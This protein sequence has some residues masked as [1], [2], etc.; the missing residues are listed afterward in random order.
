MPNEDGKERQKGNKKTMARKGQIVRG[1]DG[2]LYLVSPTGLQTLPDTKATAI[3]N[4]L[5]GLQKRVDD[6]VN[7]DGSVAAAGC[8]QHVQIIPVIPI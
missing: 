4:A 6:I 3:N 8:N 7:Q 1:A 2:T 5:P